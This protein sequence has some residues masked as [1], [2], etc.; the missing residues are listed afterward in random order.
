VGA[1]LL[2]SE[3]APDQVPALTLDVCGLA[4]QGG[5]GYLLVSLPD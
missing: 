3:Q 1:Q 4:G 2:R 5:T